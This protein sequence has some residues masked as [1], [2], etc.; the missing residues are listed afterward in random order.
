MQCNVSSNAKSC[1]CTYSSC[2]RRGKC[3]LCITYHRK[4]GELPGCLFNAEY[5]S[6]YDRSVANFLR[7]HG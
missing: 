7:M 1:T 6:T 3:C 4:K 5:E 2:E